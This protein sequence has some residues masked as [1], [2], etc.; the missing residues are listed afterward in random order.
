MFRG[1]HLH[2]TAAL[3]STPGSALQRASYCEQTPAR[4]SPWSGGF[5]IQLKSGTGEGDLKIREHGITISEQSTINS[6][7]VLGRLARHIHAM[8]TPGFGCLPMPINVQLS[9]N[10]ACTYWFNMKGNLLSA[11]VGSFHSL[12]HI[13][14]H[15]AQLPHWPHLGQRVLPLSSLYLPYPFL[16]YDFFVVIINGWLTSALHFLL[17]FAILCS[18]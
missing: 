4:G 5:D 12:G 2:L 6:C 8:D 17:V 9:Q 1:C 3:Q 10:T 18:G 7:S 11:F 14:L 13:Q 16:H 15:P